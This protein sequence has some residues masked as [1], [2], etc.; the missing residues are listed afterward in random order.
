MKQSFVIAVLSVSLGLLIEHSV[1]GDSPALFDQLT[2]TGVQLTDKVRVRLD[3]PVVSEQTDTT[4]KQHALDRIAGAS[5]WKRF[6]RD[7]SVAPIEIDMKYIED[8]SGQRIGHLVYV[9][10]VAHC[11]L[12]SLRD[13]DRM[14]KLFGSTKKEPKADEYHADEITPEQLEALH[15]DG[16]DRKYVSIRIPLLDRVLIRGVVASQY[17]EADN[18]LTISWLLDPRFATPN[19]LR[20]SNEWSRLNGDDM[21]SHPY[22]G[23]GG[24]IHVTKLS[25]PPGACL[26]ETRMVIHEPPKWFSGSNLL[27]SKLPLLVQES[28]RKFRRQLDEKK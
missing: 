12:D 26:N 7:S 1:K 13:R 18:D 24:Y 16:D 11:D 17:R 9:A 6:S 27:R 3:M 15:F 25:D 28:V 21:T 4:L 8:D 22:E 20:F 10:F 14:D 5:G 23:A 19:A 2:T